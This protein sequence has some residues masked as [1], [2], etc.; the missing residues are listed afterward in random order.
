MSVPPPWCVVRIMRGSR[1]DEGDEGDEGAG[2]RLHIDLPQSPVPNPQSPI[3]IPHYAT[4]IF[5]KNLG[6][7]YTKFGIS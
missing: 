7:W 3:P 4:Q 6:D 1:E 5:L 2:G